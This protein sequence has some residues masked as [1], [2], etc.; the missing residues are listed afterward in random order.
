[1][2]DVP[3]DT[4]RAGDEDLHTHPPLGWLPTGDELQ[5]RDQDNETITD[6]YHW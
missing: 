1:M 5:G 6:P 2:A 4:G 3:E